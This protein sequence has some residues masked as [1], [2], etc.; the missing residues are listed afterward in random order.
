MCA[1]HASV[2]NSKSGWARWSKEDAFFFP[3]HRY[4][5]KNCSLLNAG[6]IL[7]AGGLM[8]FLPTRNL[9]MVTAAEYC[10]FIIVKSRAQRSHELSISTGFRNYLQLK[11]LRHRPHRDCTL[12]VYVLLVNFKWKYRYSILY[13]YIL[14]KNNFL[15]PNR[16]CLCCHH[17]SARGHSWCGRQSGPDRCPPQGC[18]HVRM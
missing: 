6:N 4:R 8:L 17:Y 5:T 1:Y 16:K 13:S 15:L 11:I 2:N 7:P 9:P 14:N 12:H 10:N 18:K 3:T